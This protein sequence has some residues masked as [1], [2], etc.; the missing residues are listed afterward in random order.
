M[1]IT[2]KLLNCPNES[3]VNC[4]LILTGIKFKLQLNMKNEVQSITWPGCFIVCLSFTFEF[5]LFG[6]I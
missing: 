3:Q 4:E 1:N 2:A 6:V 5:D